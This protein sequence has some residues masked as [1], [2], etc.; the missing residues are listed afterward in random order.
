MDVALI[1]QAVNAALGS[2]RMDRPSELPDLRPVSQTVGCPG[3]GPYLLTVCVANEGAADAGAFD[4]SVDSRP[5]ATLNSLESGG[6][7]CLMDRYGYFG[8][9]STSVITVDPD[10]R[11]DEQNE[12]NNTL[13]FPKP[14]PTG[15]DVIC[16]PT[17]VTTPHPPRIRHPR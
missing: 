16:T 7:E 3:C 6:E 2:C 12:D 17:P 8:L 15:C 11:V 5:F 9:G 14:P 10:N 4:V 1:I 13:S